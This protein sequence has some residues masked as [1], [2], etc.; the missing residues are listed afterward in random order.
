VT[1]AARG[2]RTYPSLDEVAQVAEGSGELETPGA[3]RSYVFVRSGPTWTQQAK[4]TAA[5]G[6]ANDR[7][8][9]S[10][11]ISGSTTVVGPYAENFRIGAAYVFVGSGTTWTQQAKLTASDGTWGDY[12]GVSVAISGST[13]VVGADKYPAGRPTCICCRN[14]RA[15]PD[16]RFGIVRPSSGCGATSPA[17]I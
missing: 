9:L 7:F 17:L 15:K 5:D 3:N 2:F 8:G 13:A 16:P 12:F 10:V 14:Y 11:A 6:R 4:L 1:E